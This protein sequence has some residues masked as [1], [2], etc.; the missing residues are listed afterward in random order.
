M[1]FIY[2]ILLYL[3]QKLFLRCKAI[4]HI[5]KK[6]L[7]NIFITLGYAKDTKALVKEKLIYYT[8]TKLKIFVYE[9]N[10]IKRWKR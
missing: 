2:I 6:I 1:T 4:S 8:I 9:K 10:I 7:E 3:V 5:Y